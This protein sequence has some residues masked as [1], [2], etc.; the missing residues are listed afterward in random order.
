VSILQSG[1]LYTAVWSPSSP[2]VHQY[3]MPPMI[4]EAH[5]VALQVWQ[6]EIRRRMTGNRG[7]GQGWRGGICGARRFG[8]ARHRRGRG[9]RDARTNWR[10]RR[11]RR[12]Q[13]SSRQGHPCQQ[14]KHWDHL[15]QH[16][17]LLSIW[18]AAL[19][20][21]S[22]GSGNSSLPLGSLAPH[23]F[24]DAEPRGQAPQTFPEV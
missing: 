12:G 18:A 11:L 24:G 21:C 2:E 16:V 13:A 5:F 22:G 4:A 1:P 20:A 8:G 14:E 6:G 17:S 15:S 9:C 3:H 23:R 7:R 10:H 19:A